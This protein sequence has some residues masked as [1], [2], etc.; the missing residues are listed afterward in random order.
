MFVEEEE[1]VQN[2]KVK[3]SFG[4]FSK[5]NIE[6]KEDNLAESTKIEK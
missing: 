3:P 4:N 6:A 5:F 2:V 1:Y